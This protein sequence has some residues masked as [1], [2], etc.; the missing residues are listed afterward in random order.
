MPITPIGP[1]T[2]GQPLGIDAALIDG[3]RRAGV[4]PAAGQRELKQ[5]MDG[6]VFLK[7]LVTQ[8]TNQDPSSPMD[9]NDMIAQTTQLASMEQLTAL[10]Q[11]QQSALMIGQR[12]AAA[13]L[14]G[15]EVTTAATPSAGAITGKVTSVTFGEGEPALMIDGVAHPYSS[16]AAVTAAS[17]DD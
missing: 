13:E 11:S 1:S 6:E 12:T 7:L 3:A 2:Q 14:I 4:D 15:R 10:A 16:I 17:L 9:T 8:L 5:T